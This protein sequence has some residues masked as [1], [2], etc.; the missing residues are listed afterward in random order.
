MKGDQLKINKFLELLSDNTMERIFGSLST[1]SMLSKTDDYSIEDYFKYI[2][3]YNLSFENKSMGGKHSEFY[4]SFDGLYKFISECFSFQK[5]T[6]TSSV[7]HPNI[8]TTNPELYDEFKI[9]LR[10]MIKNTESKYYIFRKSIEE[11]LL[12]N[13]TTEL[14]NKEETKIIERKGEYWITKNNNGDFCF[15]KKVLD[16]SKTA[17][18]VKIFD[19]VFSIKPEGGDVLYSE[20]EKVCKTKKLKTTNKSV[21]KALTGKSANF[22]RFVRGVSQFPIY[23][24]P[25][26]KASSKGKYLTF[27]NK[28]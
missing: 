26:F 2:K 3:K 4:E 12:K 19:A 23:G 17:E 14:I 25:L 27:N 11:Y 20:I 10:K 18:Y 5:P 6:D 7:L 9:K 22:F 21:Q 15:D 13:D 28:K 1:S 24:N 16:L 8:R